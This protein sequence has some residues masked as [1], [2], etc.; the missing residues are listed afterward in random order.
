MEENEEII[1]SKFNLL[2]IINF[3]APKY[4]D[5]FNE[6]ED[7]K[8]SYPKLTKSELSNK[9]A[10]RIRNKYTSVGVASALP[11]V[12]PGVGT[13]AQIAIEGG[14]I[15][16]DL[17]LML[18]GMSR[19]C[20]GIGMINDKDMKQG[21]NQDLITILGIW[22]GVIVPAKIATEK[23][24]TKIAVVQFN[25]RVTG[26]MLQKINQRVGTTIVTKYGT[27]RGAVAL[28]KL[29]PFGVGAVIGGS[30]NYS[31]MKGF[32]LAAKSHYEASEDIEYVVL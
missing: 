22:S 31:T 8:S 24:A 2:T 6:V 18:R 3:V 10:K 1:K 15:S 23:L 20:Y 14:A 21:F 19:M 13:V 32:S 17:I 30:F 9:F 28:G 16:G 29:I 26:K 11:S 12:I 7:L 5:I 4:E 25:K 27:K